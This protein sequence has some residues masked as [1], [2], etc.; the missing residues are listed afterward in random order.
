MKEAARSEEGGKYFK[1][2]LN[3]K[4]NKK[5]RTMSKVKIFIKYFCI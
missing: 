4:N 3:K 1:I 5:Q 2:S